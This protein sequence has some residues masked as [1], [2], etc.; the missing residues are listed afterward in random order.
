MTCEY[1]C[2]NIHCDF[3]DVFVK[4][5]CPTVYHSLF[6][7]LDLTIGPMLNQGWLIKSTWLYVLFL[8]VCLSLTQINETI[9][10]LL[11]RYFQ[12]TLLWRLF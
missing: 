9:Y 12:F 11:R 5:I 3:V 6:M 2:D 10:T 1:V 7:N 8:T 4:Y